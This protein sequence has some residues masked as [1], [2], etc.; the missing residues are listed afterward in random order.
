MAVFMDSILLLRMKG[1]RQQIWS[2]MLT[3]ILLLLGGECP[4]N[5]HHGLHHIRN[6]KVS[7]VLVKV[8]MLVKL[9]LFA[10]GNRKDES[11]EETHHSSSN[12]IDESMDSSDSN[13]ETDR[14]AGDASNNKNAGANNVC[15][16]GLVIQ[17]NLTSLPPL[18]C[19]KDGCTILFITF[20][21]GNWECSNGHS[22]KVARYCINH[23]PSNTSN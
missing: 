23:H 11:E 20:C 6:G 7:S 3:M 19:Q 21:Q 17:C 1:K 15:D 5:Y 10:V 9:K 12:N 8:I 2:Q 18:K 13:Y 16:W 14:E 22:N 4:K